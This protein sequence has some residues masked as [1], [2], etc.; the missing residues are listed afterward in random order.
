M[1]QRQTINVLGDVITKLQCSIIQEGEEQLCPHITVALKATTQLQKKC[2]RIS[3]F[4]T[5]TTKG[6][7]LDD[8]SGFLNDQSTSTGKPR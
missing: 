1:V 3:S 5:G 8:R 4:N 6:S 7:L 2:V